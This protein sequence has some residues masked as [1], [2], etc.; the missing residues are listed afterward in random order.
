MSPATHESG[1]FNATSG[2]SFAILKPSS[3]NRVRRR[4]QVYSSNWHIGQATSA[5]SPFHAW[6]NY[7]LLSCSPSR[8]RSTPPPPVE[9]SAH[10]SDR[11]T[12][13]AC[14]GT[15]LF[16]TTGS[17][18]T[19]DYFPPVRPHP[20]LRRQYYHVTCPSLCDWSACTLI[21]ANFYSNFRQFA[22]LSLQGWLMGLTSS[23]SGCP[24]IPT[25]I[26]CTPGFTY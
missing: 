14:P 23:D 20:L 26:Q 6:L 7:P 12:V 3:P 9:A 8:C 13:T 18:L 25:G 2:W 16:V 11:L 17:P 4:H 10:V 24:I 15:L 21:P 1:A 19:I 5:K 22:K